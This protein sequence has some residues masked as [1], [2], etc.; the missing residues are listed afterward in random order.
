[1]GREVGELRRVVDE[2]LVRNDVLDHADFV[3]HI[4]VCAKSLPGVAQLEFSAA[5]EAASEIEFIQHHRLAELAVIQCMGG[6]LVVGV[7][8][9]SQAGQELLIDADIEVGGPLRLYWITQRNHR[10]LHRISEQSEIVLGRLRLHG[11]RKIA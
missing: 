8:A 9:D 4:G 3:R 5:A 11:R 7:E 1:M 10:L 6:P 2:V